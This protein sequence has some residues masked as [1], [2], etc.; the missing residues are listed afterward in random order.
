VASFTADGNLEVATNKTNLDLD[1]DFNDFNL[2]VLGSLGG[3]VIS[4]IRG[5]ASGKSNIR[6]DV[7][8][9]EINGR[10]FVK[11]AGLGIPI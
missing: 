5:F 6:G 7:D 10:L 8:N 9:L 4:N 3:D 1:L 11:K 2:G